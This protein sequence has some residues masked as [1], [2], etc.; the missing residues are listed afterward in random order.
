[1]I[2]HETFCT[3]FICI[4]FGLF[5][6]IICFSS[7]YFEYNNYKNDQPAIVFAEKLEVK[8]E[9]KNNSTTLFSLHEGTKVMVVEH[10][11]NW[12]KV[13]IDNETL[14]WVKEGTIKLIK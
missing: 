1:M 11:K 14:G 5:A 9:P 13:Y 2:L 8:T 12:K 6:G 10:K 4:I 7:A 3:Y